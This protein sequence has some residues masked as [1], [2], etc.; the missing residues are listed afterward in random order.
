MPSL[1]E[2]VAVLERAVADLKGRVETH[3]EELDN[4]PE[5]IKTEFR[6][7][8]SHIARLSRDVVELRELPSKVDA[9]HRVMAEMFADLTA[10]VRSQ[11]EK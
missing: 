6:L 11:R 2:R 10:E 1:E 5:L 7:T 3:Q 9:L 4:I 8:N